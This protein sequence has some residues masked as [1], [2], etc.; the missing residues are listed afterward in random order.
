MDRP[1][2]ASYLI[3]G[4]G[5]LPGGVPRSGGYLGREAFVA[6]IGRSRRN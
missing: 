6:V 2:L 3:A 5:V 4:Y 1:V